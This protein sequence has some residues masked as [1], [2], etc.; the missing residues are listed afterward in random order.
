M[1]KEEEK[2]KRGS[3]NRTPRAVPAHPGSRSAHR[4]R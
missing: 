2:E 1:A 3:A 4:G